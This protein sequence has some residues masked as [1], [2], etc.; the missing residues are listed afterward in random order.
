MMAGSDWTFRMNRQHALLHWST[1]PFQHTEA[2]DVRTD[3]SIAV[4]VKKVRGRVSVEPSFAKDRTRLGNKQET[5]DVMLTAAGAGIAIV[6]LNVGIDNQF[7]PAGK[8]CTTVI[9]SVTAP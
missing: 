2:S 3:A 6:E 9:L 1:V 8:H 7:A 5:A 4:K